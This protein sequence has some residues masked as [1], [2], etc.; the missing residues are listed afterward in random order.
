M[1][2]QITMERVWA[3]PLGDVWELWT[4][5]EGIE[6]WWGPDGFKTKVYQLE[7]RP[8]GA[9]EYS[10]T[11]VGAEQIAFLERAGQPIMSTVR[12]KYTVVE[13]M[14]LVAWNNLTDFIQGVEPYEVETRV[15][16]KE[17]A[18][19]VEMTLKFDVMHDERWTQMAKAGWEN[20]LEK[21]ARQ[22]EQRR[23]RS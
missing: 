8:G 18:R 21:L 10:F 3:Y 9:L 7:L 12:G 16:L 4:T 13:P 2:K 23:A 15:E 17:S 19:G 20:E 5:R 11:A 14:T 1:K 22:L 6:S